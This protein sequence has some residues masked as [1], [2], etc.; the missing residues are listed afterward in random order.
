MKDRNVLIIRLSAIGDVVRALPAVKALKQRFPSSHVAWV[1]EESSK[2]LLESQPEIDRVI[3]LPRK[4]W[5]Q[6]VKSPV[7]ALR[8]IAEMVHFVRDLRRSRFDV[9]LDFHGLLKSGLLSLFSG[10]PVRVG[11]QRPWSKEGNVFFSNVRV[12]L[13][14]GDL[15]T[16][17]RFD[18]NLALLRGIGLEVKRA[19]AGLY[20]NAS[21]RGYVKSFFETIKG[22]VRKPLIAIHPGTSQK[23]RYKRWLPDRYG[24][25]ADQLISRMGATVLFTWGPDEL[26]WVK[27]IQNRMKA[28]SFIGPRTESLTQLGEVF[29]YCDLYIGGDTG[30]MHVASLM[31]VPVV[32]VFGPTYPAVN[33]PLGRH[34]LVRKEVGCNPCRNRSC[35]EL[36]CL[37]AISVDDVY[38]A[39]EELLGRGR[40]ENGWKSQDRACAES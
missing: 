26:D 38:G 12:S 36:R 23:T 11:F 20:V 5:V 40:V 32:A 18:Q 19:P 9:A 1:V 29:R 27:D 39:A 7:T 37:E 4:R 31:E 17:N 33:A 34:T 10:A 14:P 16:L 3:V 24:E 13:P 2:S 25:L 6:A 28:S 21:D 35:A 22:S 8:T 15:R 30:P